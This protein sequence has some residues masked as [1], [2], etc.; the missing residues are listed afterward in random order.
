MKFKSKLS[1]SEISALHRVLG[2][3][4]MLPCD[5]AEARFNGLRNEY[6][7][8][9]GKDDRQIKC[10]LLTKSML[11]LNGVTKQ[12]NDYFVKEV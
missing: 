10:Q 2:A 4:Q 9:F 12:L 3:E 11:D 6:Y 5:K 8:V 7:L 1:K